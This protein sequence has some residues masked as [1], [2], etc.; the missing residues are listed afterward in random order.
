[1]LKNLELF[2]D[3][4]FSVVINN[5]K[6]NFYIVVILSILGSFLDMLSISIF[7]PLIAFITDSEF[8]NFFI[9]DYINNFLNKNLD[10]K[11]QV[12]IILKIIFSVFAIKLIYLMFV[13]YYREN[14]LRNLN[15]KLSNKYLK[16]LLRY[17][18]SFF[19]NTNSSDLIRNS[20]GE[21]SV[22]VSGIVLPVVNIITEFALLLFLLV[23]LL[24]IDFK[25]TLVVFIFFLIFSSIYF[26]ITKNYLYKWGLKR[27][28]LSSSKIKKLQEIFG[29]I[30]EIKVFS[31][32][33]N[34]LEDFSKINNKFLKYN[35]Y[36]E[37]LTKLPRLVF[38]S[39]TIFILIYLIFTLLENNNE[40]S[41]IISILG[42]FAL[43][44][45]RT[46]PSISSILVSLQ[47]LK[48]SSPS[49]DNIVNELR[50][51]KLKK[52]SEKIFQYDFN[53]SIKLN[54]IFFEYKNPKKVIFKNLNLEI[55]NKSV[56]GIFGV[57]GSGKS[58]LVDLVLGLIE[59][60]KGEINVDQT[61]IKKNHEN[62]LSLIGYVPQS[63]FLLDETLKKN[64]ILDEKGYDENK[65]LNVIA[66][67]NL[68]EL[69]K[70]KD[71]KDLFLGEK[72]VRVS[73]GQIQ[74]IGIARALYKKSKILIL[75]E[76]TASLDEDNER[77][78]LDSIIKNQ[79]GI[80]AII[81]SHKI[82][83]LREYCQQIYELKDF[84]LK[85]IE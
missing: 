36:G 37:F 12:K 83:I 39:L 48:K 11:L 19:S 6:K 1:M 34:S 4:L 3:K 32:E 82:N 67:T 13:L 8:N 5:N 21:I 43:V 26:T 45:V 52:P 53:K 14:F 40:F 38:E 2:N 55:A 29:G 78:I 60:Q 23:F 74:R 9:F 27:F 80:T 42:V 25:N 63:V 61:N 69:I 64:I 57:S 81:I 68:E 31:L 46:L 71:H 15:Y 76:A 73:G 65:Y 28:N 17:P 24:N 18:Y 16:N 7:V 58:T 66:Q 84:G 33:N 79:T 51:E 72:G 62:W 22:I 20:H 54:N 49:L 77:K 50:E 85:K 44:A 30:K 56:T 70:N 47:N 35:F 10:P 41:K 75:D 59:P